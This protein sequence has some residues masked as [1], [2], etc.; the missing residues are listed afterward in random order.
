MYDLRSSYKHL[1]CNYTYFFYENFLGEHDSSYLKANFEIDTRSLRPRG[2][3]IVF[4]EKNYEFGKVLEL[5][6]ICIFKIGDV[7]MML[8]CIYPRFCNKVTEE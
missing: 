6:R 1:D 3:G 8:K 7:K 2:A 5:L 4:Q